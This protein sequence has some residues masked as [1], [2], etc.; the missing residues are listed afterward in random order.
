MKRLRRKRRRSRAQ[1]T[2]VRGLLGGHSGSDR[3]AQSETAVMLFP[4]MPLRR[5]TMVELPRAILAFS[6]SF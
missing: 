1:F 3:S 6:W 2:V 5:G 4:W